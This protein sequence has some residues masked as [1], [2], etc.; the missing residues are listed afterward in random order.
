MRAYA[1]NPTPERALQNL[2]TE[3]E[4]M[5]TAV[6]P[7]P[8]CRYGHAAIDAARRSCARHQ[9]GQSSRH[10]WPAESRACC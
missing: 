7:Y 3:F 4:L 5:Q 8:S 2:G 9:P 6:K 10:P 1:P